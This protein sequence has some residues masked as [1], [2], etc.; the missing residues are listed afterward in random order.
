V[1]KQF[2]ELIRDSAFGVGNRRTLKAFYGEVREAVKAGR[3]VLEGHSLPATMNEWLSRLEGEHKP[4]AKDQEVIDFSL[5]EDDKFAAWR[6]G[7]SQ[8][9]GAAGRRGSLYLSEASRDLLQDVQALAGAKDSSM[10][11][12]S[13]KKEDLVSALS[14]LQ[15][16]VSEF[17][18]TYERVRG[19][20]RLPDPALELSRVKVRKASKVGRGK[21]SA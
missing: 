14:D 11:G 10:V 21:E 18:S 7:R 17:L 4:L 5:A 15:A 8:G 6:A 19:P 1:A 9:R 13:S 20:L 3:L 12:A 2:S 16:A